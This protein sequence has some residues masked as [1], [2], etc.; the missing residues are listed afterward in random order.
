M[1][2]TT[3]ASGSAR[4]DTPRTD[5]GANDEVELLLVIRTMSIAGPPSAF[6]AIH[7]ASIRWPPV[8]AAH[9]QNHGEGQVSSR[10]G[11]EWVNPFL[12]RLSRCN[13]HLVIVH[14]VGLWPA[15]VEPALAR[16]I[17]PSDTSMVVAINAALAPNTLVMRRTR[18]VTPVDGDPSY[19]ILEGSAR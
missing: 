10:D 7:A 14:D 6:E 9:A 19:A 2:W 12:L 13:V 15:E 8:R 17:G 4:G 5:A 1:A 11:C 16:L 3:L 18:R